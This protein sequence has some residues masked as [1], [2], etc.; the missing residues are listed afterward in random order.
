MDTHSYSEI[1]G[2]GMALGTVKAGLVIAVWYIRSFAKR[3]GDAS[4]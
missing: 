2:I 1:I 3:P 4:K